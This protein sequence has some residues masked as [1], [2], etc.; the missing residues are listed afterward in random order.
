MPKRLI[1]VSVPIFEGMVHWPNDPAF[2]R[3]WVL[4][5]G[6][7]GAPCN[8]SKISL[9]SHT[10]THMD[11]PLHFLSN[12]ATMETLPVEATIGPAR[13]IMIR[14]KVSVNPDEL[15]AFKLRAG[16]RILLKTR[17]SHRAWKMGKFDEDF[18]YISKEGAAYLAEKKIQTIGIDYLSVGGFRRDSIETHCALLGAGIWI[19]EGLN[20]S[21]AKPGPCELICLPLKVM[22]A[23]GAPARAVLRQ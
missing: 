16:E 20:L 17:N 6:K 4:Q 2:K 11:A 9:G 3:E 8:V 10:G 19:I 21:K 5:K 13:I 12:G 1:D 23:E 15:R 18:V 7:N 22:G 14:D